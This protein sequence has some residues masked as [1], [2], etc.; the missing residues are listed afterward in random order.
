MKQIDIPVYND[1]NDFENDNVTYPC[2][3]Q[4]M[5]YNGLVHKYYLT[6]EALNKAGI[7]VERKYIYN[8]QN[9]T[10]HFIELVS[11][12]IYDY[13]CYKAG[14][15]NFQVQMYRIATAPKQ[16]IGDQYAFRKE[17]ENVLLAEARWLID[18]QDSAQYSAV[19]IEKGEKNGKK[20]EEN[21][22]DTNDI[23]VEAKRQLKFLG[24]DRWFTLAPNWR[25]DT[26]KY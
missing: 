4:Y 16:M 14:W 18:N 17:F 24:L 7:D 9:K 3:T 1:P 5:V 19:D 12:K 8:G 21:W 20:P 11:K 6:E 22:E 15:V 13:I 25:V 26:N 10:Q 2:S 23:A